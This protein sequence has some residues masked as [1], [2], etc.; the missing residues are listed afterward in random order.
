VGELISESEFLE[1]EN[2]QNLSEPG[3]IGL[4]WFMGI[5]HPQPHL[6]KEGSFF[7]PAAFYFLRLKA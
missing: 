6:E 2:L 1:L 4:I 5:N 3:F 7:F